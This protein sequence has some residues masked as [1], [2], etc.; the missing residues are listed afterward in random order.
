MDANKEL[1]CRIAILEGRCSKLTAAA[2]TIAALWLITILLSATP[3]LTQ[4]AYGQET[5][6][7]LRVHTLVVVDER[8]SERVRIGAPDSRSTEAVWKVPVSGI[9][10][11]DPEGKE[12]G[13]FV[14]TNSKPSQACLAVV[15]GGHQ[16]IL[17]ANPNDR[18]VCQ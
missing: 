11:Y 8:G 14:T 17:F 10:F 2:L 4:R 7:S 18:V 6:D 15:A 13:G 16:P 1:E 9:T 5:L 12:R 3:F